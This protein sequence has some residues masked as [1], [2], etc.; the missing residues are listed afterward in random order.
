LKSAGAGANLVMIRGVHVQGRIP[1]RGLRK[2]FTPEQGVA[3]RV[4]LNVQP[5]KLHLEDE[6]G[7]VEILALESSRC[8]SH[9]RSKTRR[10][11]DYV[12]GSVVTCGEDYLYGPLRRISSFPVTVDSHAHLMADKAS[13]SRKSRTI[14]SINACIVMNP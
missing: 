1:P 10:E 11:R 5:R 12:S 9:C 4:G 2:G 8:W 6:L 13:L 7:G 14:P 3:S